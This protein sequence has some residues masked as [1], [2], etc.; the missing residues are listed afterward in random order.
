[1]FECSGVTKEF[2]D[3]F[4]T[5]QMRSKIGAESAWRGFM[6]Q[7]LYIATRISDVDE[8]TI[9][10]PETVED[11]LVVKHAGTGE[12]SLELVQV[13]S[14]SGQNLT[15]SRLKPSDKSGKINEDSFFGHLYEAWKR[16]IRAD[17]K[18]IVFGGVSESLKN[19]EASFEP[20]SEM[21]TKFVKHYGYSDEYCAWLQK[22]LCVELVNENDLKDRLTEVLHA[23]VE[24]QAAVR[25]ASAYLRGK[26][27]K[28]CRD[29]E[30]L[31]LARWNG[32]LSEFGA[33]K[34]SNDEFHR[35]Y[36]TTVVPL[37]EYLAEIDE[38]NVQAAEE[39]ASGSSATPKHIALNLDINRP[40]WLT[41]IDK[42]FVHSNIVIVRGASGE[43]KS[44]ICYRWLMGRSELSPVYLIGDITSVSAPQIAACLRGLAKEQTIYAYLE[45]DANVAWVSL[46][47]EVSRISNKH[48]RV[49][50]SVRNDDAARSGY[51]VNLIEGVEIPLYLTKREAQEFYDSVCLKSFNNFEDAWQRF[52]EQGPLLEFM[53]F[54]NHKI[55]L[56][57]KLNIQLMSLIDSGTDSW[58][59]FLYL[60]SLTGSYGLPATISSLAEI[61]GC[62]DVI[63][64][65]T[66]L[67]SEMLFRSSD[68]NQTVRPLHPVRAQ[69]IA[70]ILETVVYQEPE[71]LL[72]EACACAVGDFTPILVSHLKYHE[73]TDAGH[74]A[75]V[76][77][78][79]NSWNSCAQALRL[80]LWKDA[81]TAFQ[82]LLEIP[83][84]IAEQQVPLTFFAF[85]A[86]GIHSNRVAEVETVLEL[87]EDPRHRLRIKEIVSEFASEYKVRNHTERYLRAISCNLPA[88]EE[89][90]EAPSS[91]GFVL[92][93]MAEMQ[94]YTISDH[95]I[96]KDL[97][98]LDVTKC[99][100]LDGMLDLCFALT[101]CNVRLSQKQVHR[102]RQLL[103][104]RDDIVAILTEGVKSESVASSFKQRLTAY[105]VPHCG[106]DASG[107]L[108]QDH[109]VNA[110]LVRAV[111]D[112]RRIWPG[113]DVYGAKII[114]L[115]GLISCVEPFDLKKEISADLLVP[116]WSTMYNQ[117][118][119][120]MCQYEE[121]PH[122][123]W[124]D[125][126]GSLRAAVSSVFAVLG[127]MVNFLRVISDSRSDQIRRIH[128]E[129][130]SAID[131]AK[132]SIV[133]ARLV[134]PKSVCDSASFQFGLDSSVS[135]AE[136]LPPDSP[137]VSVPGRFGLSERCLVLDHLSH[138]FSSL[139]LL[140]KGFVDVSA[141]ALGSDVVWS[142]AATRAVSC[143]CSLVDPCNE[144][145]R[146]MFG[147][148]DLVSPR[149]RRLPFTLLGYLYYFQ[150]C[151]TSSSD[152]M[153]GNCLNLVLDSSSFFDRF[154]EAL[155][156]IRSVKSARFD[157][158]NVIDVDVD[159]PDMFSSPE[160][161]YPAILNSVG[162]DS[163]FEG[164][165]FL[166]EFFQVSSPV[167][168][169]LSFDGLYGPK[170]ISYN[171]NSLACS[172]LSAEYDSDRDLAE[173]ESSVGKVVDFVQVREVVR[174]YLFLS[175][176]WL[177]CIAVVSGI[178]S[179]D[180][181]AP[182][183][184][185]DS[186]FSEW[187]NDVVVNLKCL[188]HEVEVWFSQYP[189]L[190]D[191]FGSQYSSICAV[192]DVCC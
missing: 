129:L 149:Q 114:G 32:L 28:A 8:N 105:I 181:L 119:F 48:L 83:H 134:V 176:G 23:H 36:G 124:S 2:I 190:R 132:A 155:R 167:M 89:M 29:R 184:V 3:K 179:E 39:Y 85:L 191:E 26:L 150:L 175:R 56:R 27:I 16:N 75:F 108:S 78:A 109:S 62:C 104:K 133:A 159:S 54:L 44:T 135:Q 115:E 71:Q 55:T 99:E 38:H 172:A 73:F 52:G 117:Y 33:Q 113:Y 84:E 58:V 112:L 47:K 160:V 182:G 111:Y 164:R 118:I 127:K 79:C 24:T 169:V 187:S 94:V 138:L 142:N 183:D 88:V 80:M 67:D 158:I 76:K 140:V 69:I 87:V 174:E 93:L 152:P 20:G 102:I 18:L 14:V 66:R 21:R 131:D 173:Q 77:L 189:V 125:L 139:L 10:F 31:S 22:H 171:F 162:S 120:A 86:F 68:D 144:E 188:L 45:A 50:V 136:I 43:G 128:A 5:G 110:T 74:R 41:K 107:E 122:G 90:V 192:I 145:F 64:L 49:L 4:S 185:V 53:Y 123:N 60:A 1:M 154:V 103:C 42:A 148:E 170:T 9:F 168:V 65:L 92:Y 98:L 19:I 166:K 7:A 59:H 100:D 61:S 130:S 81:N 12:E 116:G 46:L 95:S 51:D 72:L 161:L 13:K 35:H 157:H 156:R 17:A 91:A 34:A 141:K 163:G 153:L 143:I 40:D 30:P 101:R 137:F 57:D 106:A 97:N 37:M 186:V 147:G 11:L 165:R 96:F 121:C 82:G 146:Q 25:A 63:K 178:L 70:Q 151:Y 177:E 6:L 126:E 180:N 15:I